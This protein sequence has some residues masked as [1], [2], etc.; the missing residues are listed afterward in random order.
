VTGSAGRIAV[1]DDDASVRR[2]LERL[3]RSAGYEVDTYASVHAFLA[4]D[5]LDGIACLVLDVRMPGPSGLDLQTVLA[6]EGRK[7]PIV[8]ITGHGDI[9]MAVRAM[10]AGAADFLS[11]P[12]DADEL[13]RAIQQATRSAVPDGSRPAR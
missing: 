8:F 5:E 10:K 4:A 9:S 6:T 3:L 13:F 7:I 2:G 11:K 1:V 12:F